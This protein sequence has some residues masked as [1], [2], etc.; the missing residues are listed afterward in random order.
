MKRRRRP[1]YAGN[2]RCLLAVSSL[3]GCNAGDRDRATLDACAVWK[4]AVCEQAGGD[5]ET[6]SAVATT[7]P[8]LSASVCKLAQDDLAYTRAVL[9]AHAR[10]CAEL[11]ARLC[12]DVGDKTRACRMVQEQTSHF[13][14][15]RCIAMLGNYAEV[16]RNLQSLSKARQLPPE[17]TAKLTAGEPPS[18]GPADAPLQLVAFMDFENRDSPKA[19]V[20]VRALQAKYGEKLRYVVREFPL[21]YNPHARLAAEAALAAHA[22]G[23]FWPMYDE[24]L[25]HREQLDRSSLL[26]Y[27]QAAGLNLETFRSA[28]DQHRYAGAVDAE[29]ALVREL[30]VEGMPTMFLNGERLLNAVDQKIVVDAVEER[31]AYPH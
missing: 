1:G 13:P 31:L 18:S 3:L 26:R 30:A 5:S 20:I 9:A 22:Q 14:P 4:T 24:L 15:E 7:L 11:A 25:A 19:A 23:K 8:L 16:L 21:P 29:L 27:A 10:K 2:F 28:L 17:Q 12:R 6:C